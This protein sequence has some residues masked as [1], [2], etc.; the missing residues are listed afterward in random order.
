MEELLTTRSE[1]VLGRTGTIV[2][3]RRK[4]RRCKGG[5]D[6]GG[7]RVGLIEELQGWG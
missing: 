7:A 3:R 1:V 4:R 5:V 2:K 6:R